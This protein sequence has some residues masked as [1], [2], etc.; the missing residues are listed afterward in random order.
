M[1]LENKPYIVAELN[2]S[3]KGKIEVA[4]KMIDAAKEC[5]CDAVKF[6]SWTPDSLYCKNYYDENP[7]SRRMV[8]G[9]SLEAEKLKEL[10]RYCHSIG[11]DFSS[12]P[13]SEEE[14]D[15]LTE[16]CDP[17]FI[18]IASMDINNL[19]FLKYI[20]RKQLPIVLSTGMATVDEIEKAVHTI[21][22]AGNRQ[23]GIL[24]CVSIYPVDSENVNL[25][26]MVML[27]DRFSD[28]KVG[29]SDHTL[30]NEVACAAVALGAVMVEKHFTLD[31]SVIGWD[32]QM[33]TE[34]EDMEKLIKGCRN[35]YAALGNYERIVSEAE[36]EQQKKMRRSLVA[37]RDLKRGK[38][39][40]E[41]DITSKRPETGIPVSFYEKLIGK[42][43]NCDVGADELIQKE[44]VD[45][46]VDG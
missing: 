14:V 39:L 4:R 30:G 34:P 13:Y 28:Y 9:F 25:N 2:S 23:I 26:N 45:W 33:A 37:A 12:T 7:I 8:K 38:I 42:S 21:E 22:D 32:N 11:I 35:V 5:G 24:H 29:Y 10:A 15:F 16:E 41:A 36:M 31:S 40:S 19:P 18:K 6:Q 44:F 43:L 46:G 17:A 20:A 27:K 1:F 3:H